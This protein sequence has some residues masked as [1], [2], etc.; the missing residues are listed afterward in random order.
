M[1]DKK[2]FIFC[3]GLII[4]Y[5]DVDCEWVYDWDFV[6]GKLDKVFVEVK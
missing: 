3:L 6:I 4:Y 5:I 1:W 2:D